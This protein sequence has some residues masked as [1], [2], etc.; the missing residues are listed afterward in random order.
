MSKPTKLAV[1]DR[2]PC[3]FVGCDRPGPMLAKGFSGNGG[4]VAFCTEHEAEVNSLRGAGDTFKLLQWWMLARGQ[5][6]P[7]RKDG[8]R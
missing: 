1:P 8:T 5:D 6:A 3:G 7:R 4:P 2:I